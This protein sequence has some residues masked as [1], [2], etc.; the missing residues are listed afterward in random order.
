MKIEQNERSLL[1]A[2]SGIASQLAKYYHEISDLD[3]EKTT[4]S[5]CDV[6]RSFVNRQPIGGRERSVLESAGIVMGRGEFFGDRLHIP[7]RAIASRALSTIPGSKGGYL[8]GVDTATPQDLMSPYSVIASSGA[9]I[10][11][12]LMSNLSIPRDTGSPQITWIGEN[13]SGPNESPPTLGNVSLVQKT[14]LATIKFS[15][16]LLRQGA[17]VEEYI[18][19][20]LMRAAG[21]ALDKAFFSGAGGLEPLGLLQTAGIGTQ[22]GSSLAHA[23]TLT[24]RGQ[25]LDAGGREENLSWV[26]TPTVQKTLAGRERASGGGRFLWDDNGVLGQSA[27]ATKNAPAGTLVCGD[28]SQSTV[29]IFGAGLDVEIDTSQDFNTGGLVARVLLSCDV[30]FPQPAAFSVATSV[31]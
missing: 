30:A 29:G 23:G 22:N 5:M 20:R 25:V 6:L 21:E 4:F 9:T 24:M 7:F 11:I 28:F 13:A 27:H 26:G 2:R 16:Q 8:V 31:S 19:A 10:L 18:R 3:E 14:A 15:I 12:G 17:S 1:A